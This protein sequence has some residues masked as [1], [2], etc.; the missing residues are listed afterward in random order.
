MPFITFEGIEGSGKSIQAQ[1]LAAVLGPTTVLTHEPGGTALGRS[2]RSLLLDLESR[3]MA[4]AA[5]VLLF[6]ADRAQHVAEVVRPALEAGRTVVSDRYVDSSLAYQGYGRR[7]PLDLVRAAAEL[8]TGGLSPDLTVL[9]DVPV[10]VGLARVAARG[11]RD[12]MEGEV[13]EFHERVRAGYQAL[14]AQ[15]PGRWV[16]IDATG[17]PDGV[18]TL[19]LA[20]LERRGLAVGHGLR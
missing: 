10:E 11:V 3:D 8:A 19:V 1:R 13:R 2:I 16:R 6:F 12:R 5:E 9:L 18:A 14:M 15:D 17:T 4:P 20:A 7:V